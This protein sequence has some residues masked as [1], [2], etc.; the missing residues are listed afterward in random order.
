MPSSARTKDKLKRLRRGM[1]LELAYDSGYREY[2]KLVR[3]ENVDT[4]NA[5]CLCIKRR[6]KCRHSRV[7][8]WHVY[9]RCNNEWPDTPTT[10][11]SGQYLKERSR[12]LSPLEVLILFGEA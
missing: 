11:Y 3:I 12:E 7:K 4:P 10:H 1:V 8:M 6:G 2:L 9:R 5:A